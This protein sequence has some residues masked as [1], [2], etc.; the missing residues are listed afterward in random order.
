[1]LKTQKNIRENA[2]FKN[3]CLWHYKNVRYGIQFMQIPRDLHK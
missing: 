1:M 3:C 2:L